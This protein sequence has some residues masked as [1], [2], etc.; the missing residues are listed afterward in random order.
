MKQESKTSG[1]SGDTP[2]TDPVLGE[3]ECASIAGTK[4][5]PSLEASATAVYHSLPTMPPS[6]R[7]GI[8]DL[9]LIDLEKNPAPEV[10]SIPPAILASTPPPDGLVVIVV[11]VAIRLATDIGG[12]IAAAERARLIEAAQGAVASVNYRWYAKGQPGKTG[13]GF[14]P[15]TYTNCLLHFMVRARIEDEPLSASP[16]SCTIFLSRGGSAG[17]H[18]DTGGERPGLGSGS[19]F[20]LDVP[21]EARSRITIQNL[22]TRIDQF[23]TL[24]PRHLPGRVTLIREVRKG[25]RAFME[26]E[27]EIGESWDSDTTVRDADIPPGKSAIEKALN[28][29]LDADK[30]DLPERLARLEILHNMTNGLRGGDGLKRGWRATRYTL[31]IDSALSSYSD[32]PQDDYAAR[33]EALDLVQL[34]CMAF[35]SNVRGRRRLFYRPLYALLPAVEQLMVRIRETRGELALL[36][37][38]GTLRRATEAKRVELGM[39]RAT[40]AL[41]RRCAAVESGL[42]AEE[43]SLELRVNAGEETDLVTAL[44]KGIQVRLPSILGIE[45]EPDEVSGEDFCALVRHVLPAA[46]EVRPRESLLPEP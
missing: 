12:G 31:E 16:L 36:R 22:K 37:G 5:S 30:D 17:T 39:L 44:A 41:A 18:W 38:I 46:T 9:Y 33:L 11:D 14:S 35:L 34:H 6:R 4:T 25:A 10:L 3:E 7:T 24:N 21:P 8:W 32:L 2:A 15:R 27:N 1:V 42:I 23:H 28:Y 40:G 19:T 29:Y 45:K 43:N 26:V 20:E 13:A